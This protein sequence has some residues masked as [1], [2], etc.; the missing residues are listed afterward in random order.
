DDGDLAARSA[1][2]FDPR[3]DGARLP[4]SELA[5]ARAETKLAGASHG[6]AL[7]ALAGAREWLHSFRTPG[8][9][10]TVSRLLGG[11]VVLRLV[12]GAGRFDEPEQPRDRLGVRAGRFGVAYRLELLGRHEEQL[13]D[14]QMGDFVDARA[15]LRREH[16]HL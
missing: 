9:R 10:R 11:R 3:G 6:S 7:A 8:R 2:L 4:E 5:A 13:L 12:G 1:R 16:R 14:N 15:H